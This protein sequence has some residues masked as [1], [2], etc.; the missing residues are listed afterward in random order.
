MSQGSDSTGAAKNYSMGNVG[1]GARIVQG[2]NNTWSEGLRIQPGGA[3]LARELAVLLDGIKAD[4]SLD[5]DDRELAVDKA[6][7]VADALP[8]AAESPDILRKALRD[9]KQ[10]FGST[11]RWFWDRLQAVLASE[12]GRQVLGTITDVAAR[13]AI[14]GLLGI[15][16]A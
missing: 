15:S 11:A 1:D 6:Q 16:V 9:A 3:Q 7:A 12:P 5:P 2:D 10:F 14:Q 8:K 4:T 13:S